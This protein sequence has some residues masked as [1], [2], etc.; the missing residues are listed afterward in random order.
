VTAVAPAVA[1][2]P[3]S[4]LRWLVGAIGALTVATGTVQMACPGFVLRF[5]ADPDDAR[6]RHFF[7][8]VGM[9]MVLFGGLLLHDLV[10]ERRSRSS[11]VIL[12]WCALQKF[13]ASGAVALG[14]AQ[15]I[16]SNLGW[17]VAGLDFASG[18]LFWFYRR[19]RGEAG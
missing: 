7:A 8:I 6:A 13:G 14:V 19:E 3:S 11:G 16:F 9:F 10:E 12:L 17:L 5:V 4:L 1:D 15:A 2:R 18:V